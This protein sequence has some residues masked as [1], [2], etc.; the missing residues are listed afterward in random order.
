V[1]QRGHA[2]RRDYNYL[3]K[4]KIIN[5]EEDFCTPQYIVSS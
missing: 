2:K 1:G 5:W 4:K 3:L